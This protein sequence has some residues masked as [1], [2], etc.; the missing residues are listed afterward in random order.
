[1]T[2]ATASSPLHSAIF[3]APGRPRP[4]ARR[5]AIHNRTAS[6]HPPATLHSAAPPRTA[7]RRAVPRSAAPRSAAPRAARIG[8]KHT[9]VRQGRCHIGSDRFVVSRAAR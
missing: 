4:L 3:L 9:N 8:G 1:M 6:V 5:L 2:A 7:P